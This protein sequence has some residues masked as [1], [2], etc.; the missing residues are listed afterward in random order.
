MRIARRLGFCSCSSF[1]ASSYSSCCSHCSGG[2]ARAVSES[3][4]KVSLEEE[5]RVRVAVECLCV[6]GVSTCAHKILTFAAQKHRVNLMSETEKQNS[7]LSNS[8]LIG[9]RVTDLHS[10]YR[11]IRQADDD[12]AQRGFRFGGDGIYEEAGPDG[13]GKR[14][15]LE[16]RRSSFHEEETFEES[17]K[18]EIEYGDSDADGS[19]EDVEHER[20]ERVERG[21]H[22]RDRDREQR[23]ALES[24]QRRS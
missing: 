15:V 16:P 5:M 17:F 2:C 20:M 8:K 24:E 12:G 1:L 10:G 6:D 7:N 3:R 13:R 4:R 19:L 14:G 9:V 21:S 23:E 18:E 22:A 11:T